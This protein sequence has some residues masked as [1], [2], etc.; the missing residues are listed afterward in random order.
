MDRIFVSYAFILKGKVSVL[1]PGHSSGYKYSR[2]PHKHGPDQEGQKWLPPSHV[3]P[4]NGLWQSYI[5]DHPGYSTEED[6]G[7]N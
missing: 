1:T 5:L 3:P 7:Q 6:T 4:H 2:H